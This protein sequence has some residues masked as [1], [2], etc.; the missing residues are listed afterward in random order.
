M[1]NDA[2][3]INAVNNLGCLVGNPGE[4]M[5]I[6]NPGVEVI[7]NLGVEHENHDIKNP[8][9]EDVESPGVEDDRAVENQD[10]ASTENGK[11]E[12]I[13]NDQEC[14]ENE[15]VENENQGIQENESSYNLRRNRA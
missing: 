12:T 5:P 4:V 14:M 7:E 13:T 1:A 8:E 6:K 9:V 3:E 15:E 2:I 11:S 10:I